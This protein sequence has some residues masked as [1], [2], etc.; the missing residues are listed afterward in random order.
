M[1]DK[2]LAMER[3]IKVGYMLKPRAIWFISLCTALFLGGVAHAAPQ[4]DLTCSSCHGMPPEDFAE[5]DPDTGAF[6][7]S[8]QN[9]QPANATS[10]NCTVCHNVNFTLAKYSTSHRD[11][12]ISFQNALNASPAA[13]A[14]YT[15]DGVTY[16]QTVFKNQTSIPVLGSCA[17][18]NCHFES[19]TPVWGGAFT[20]GCNSC[21]NAVPT[22]KSHPAHFG[23]NDPETM[24]EKCHNNHT[25]DAM[26]Y[27][28]ATSA[29]HRPIAVN[30][31]NGYT[32]SNGK[33]LPSQVLDR[34]PGS[35]ASASCHA[36]PYG[37][38]K[39]PSPTWGGNTV[40]CIVCHKD[41]GAF[42]ANYAPDS[43]SHAAHM[44]VPDTT[45]G[46]CHAG[47]VNNAVDTPFGGTFH[48]DGDIDVIGGYPPNVAKHS[49]NSG[50]SSCT[51]ASCHADPYSENTVTSPV[52]GQI[53][54][55][56]SCHRGVGAFAAFGGPSTGS[57]TSHMKLFNSACNQCHEGAEKNV[58]GGLT[59]PKGK[60]E[61]SNDY[62][63]SPVTKHNPGTYTGYCMSA[64]CHASPYGFGAVPSP[65][66]N[67]K[68]GCVSC[69]TNDIVNGQNGTFAPNGAPATGSHSKH[70]ALPNVDCGLCHV[71]AKSGEIGGRSHSNGFVNVSSGYT[72][73]PVPRH[74]IGTYGGTC[75]N[76]CHT[77][78]NGTSVPSSKWGVAMSA[79]CSG[80]HGGAANV[81]PASKIIATGKHRSH[82]NNYST[83]G[84]GNNFKCAECHAKTTAMASD[85]ALSGPGH[86]NGFKDYSGVKAGGSSNYS[87]ATGVCSTVYCHSNGQPVP[88]FVTM[89]GS[90][91]WKENA[92]FDCSGCHG[93]EPGA[94]WKTTYG[95]PNYPN[96]YDGTLKTANSHERHNVLA[97]ATDSRSC[98]KCHATSVDE[99][100]PGKLRNYSTTH[101]NKVRDVSFAIYGRYS[102]TNR[103]CTTY[104]HSNVQA[105]GGEAP[106][107]VYAQPVWGDNDSMT[108]A[109]CHKDMAN[110]TETAENLQLGSHRR[111][112]APYT[113]LTSGSLGAG[114]D[115]SVCHSSSYSATTANTVKHANGTINVEF[116][117]SR[118]VGTTYSQ[119]AG[120]LPGDTYG[121]CSTSKCHGRATQNWGISTTDRLCEKC[122]GSAR[123][124]IEQGIFK[125]TAGSPASPYTGTH[126]SHVAG[127]HKLMAPMSCTQCHRMPTSINSFGHMS[128][129]PAPIFW[130]PTSQRLSIIRAGTGVLIKP[131]GVMMTPT[132][133]PGSRQCNNTYCHAG[134]QI[135]DIN[136][137]VTY[138]GSKPNPTWADAGYLAGTGC[139]MC[140]GYP[141]GGQHPTSTICSGCHAH[142]DQSNL[143]FVQNDPVQQNDVRNHL[144]GSINVTED[145]CLGC[146]SS[147]G[148][149]PA[150]VLAKT[151]FSR[152][153]VGGHDTH[154]NSELFLKNADLSNKKLSAG[155]YI[156]SSWIYGITY[157]KGFPQYACGFCHPMDVAL[158]KNGVVEVDLNPN[159]AFR[160]SVKTKNKAEGATPSGWY[161]TWLKTYIPGSINESG[162]YLSGS[163][164]CNNVYC[165]STGYV[166]EKTQQYQFKET[167]DWYYADSHGGV[168]P[169]AGQD[170]CAKCHGNSPNTRSVF[171]NT[172]S[173][174]EGSSAHARHVVANHF[175]DVFIG[176]S[177]GKLAPAGPAGSGAVHGD[178]ST[179]TNFNCNIC[180][181]DTVR[182][183]YNDKGNVCFDCHK[184]TGGTIAGGIKGTMVV[185]SS[186]TKHVNGDVDV[187]FMAPF[188][189]KSKAQV[190]DNI[191][192]IQSVYTSWTRVNGYKKKNSYDLA[193]TTPV[194]AGGTCSTTACHNNTMMEWRTKGPLPCAA[195]HT[196][197]S[198]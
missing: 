122:H 22:T 36:D 181:Y 190:R 55:C 154:T 81:T 174:N 6:Q 16:G 4:L 77:D 54:G 179:S 127:T 120:N 91:A 195:C 142:V 162:G 194:Y 188:A 160:G 51:N 151:C 3:K 44:L 93:H 177:E 75:A 5:R 102:T 192:S 33:F 107:T 146:H 71:G 30:A 90:K 166:S 117:G 116:T 106:A 29:A 62:T 186:S 130:G 79:N 155:D 97:G 31:D 59:H 148:C 158:H 60:I 111:H 138:Q 149:T 12:K 164:V 108:C 121:S 153:L 99:T 170:T 47:T 100:V 196:G 169:W 68:S 40:G 2:E 72:H 48:T 118:A 157:K 101:L 185:Y 163:V 65:V 49:K 58:S 83:L 17:N 105:P 191:A 88:R 110:L 57:H 140:H 167:P 172:T 173:L 129:L 114:Y 134:V 128:T 159:N 63:A 171:N 94:T 25:N 135:K 9:H 38:G 61:V 145:E 183:P 7:G 139:N 39:I 21:H 46:Q 176:Y 180:H 52:W 89:T 10:A 137:V 41:S 143:A 34:Q 14:K 1:A 27:Q 92:K 141:P 126:L 119:A 104:C 184:S 85:I 74:P 98:A 26:P 187:T 165:H 19:T 28:H 86:V 115:C 193:R 67:A 178:P 156:D 8:H 96:K 53:S 13:D 56:A 112:V 15:A 87:V 168:S 50:Y 123:T 84:A 132:Y 24:C 69:H 37:P 161:N 124:A 152:E 66:W 32:G 11:G 189:V 76:S 133:S 198:Q 82:M 131:D 20:E 80:C 45:C 78:G 64:S 70:M 147:D 42:G 95:A 109:S 103:S 35:C 136:G 125:D 43:G 175:K 18:I 182:T 197:L 144:N 150:E 113:N 73:S 23:L